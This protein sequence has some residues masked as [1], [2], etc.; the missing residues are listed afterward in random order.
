MAGT[1]RHIGRVAGTPNKATSAAR[2][3]IALFVENNAHRLQEWLDEI[4]NGI[5]EVIEMVDKETGL[6]TAT[7]TGK[8]IVPPNPVKAYELFQSVIEYHV[9]KLTRTEVTGKDGGPIDVQTTELARKKLDA[10]TD[11]A[12][13]AQTYANLVSARQ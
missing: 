11:N 1:L 3:A 5:P 4:A 10:E 13:A 6:V 8:W 7:R 2:Q 12:D 9:P